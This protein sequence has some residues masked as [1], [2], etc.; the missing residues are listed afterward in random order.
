M[1]TEESI[2]RLI[3]VYKGK[4]GYGY[5]TTQ[6]KTVEKEFTSLTVL[7]KWVEENGSVEEF[8]GHGVTTRLSLCSYKTYRIEC[9][10]SYEDGR[11][12]KS[13][14]ANRE[15]KVGDEVLHVVSDVRIVS[16]LKGVVKSISCGRY[17]DVEFE[18]Y[19]TQTFDFDDMSVYKE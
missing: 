14:A 2:L 15:F 12:Y 1:K 13:Y 4:D 8:S 6:T 19:G 10:E 18:D 9:V 11:S 5:G 7:R 16:P 3:A 17:M